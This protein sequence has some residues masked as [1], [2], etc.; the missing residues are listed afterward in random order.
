MNILHLSSEYPPQHVYGLGRYVGELAEAQAR[1]GHLVEVITNSFGGNE[2]DLV[3]NGVRVRRVHFPPP[4]KA[5]STSSMILHFNLQL[6]ER[7][8]E[9]HYG[10]RPEFDVIN[11]HDWLTFP[12]AFHLARLAKRPL[13]TTIHDVVFNKVRDRA[14]ADE[15][16]YVAG[17]ENWSCHTS[18][19]IVVLSETVRQEVLHAYSAPT[20]K[21]VIVPGGVGIEPLARHLVGELLQRRRNW[22]N[23]D[24]DLLLYVGRL[25]SEK[26]LPTLLEA[27][28]LLR[29]RRRNGW[30][31][32]LAGTGRHV[33]VLTDWIQKNEMTD[34]VRLLGYL[35]FSELRLAYAAADIAIVPSDY[36]PFG[37]VALE[38]QRMG[39]PV[40]VARTGGLAETILQTEGGLA[41]PPG[42]ADALLDSIGKLLADAFQRVKLGCNGQ[43]AVGRLFNWQSIANNRT[44]LYEKIKNSP[45]PEN[46]ELPQWK[47]PRESHCQPD[48]IRQVP[49]RARIPLS[50]FVV[51]WD[52]GRI[53][54]LQPVLDA[55]S[56]SHALSVLTGTIH[57]VRVILTPGTV[58]SMPSFPVAPCVRFI[59]LLNS[60]DLSL[61]LRQAAVAIADAASAQQLLQSGLIDRAKIPVI[62]YGS[63]NGVSLGE[64][65]V[66]HPGDL[67]TLGTK[68]LCDDGLRKR[69]APQLEYKIPQFTLKKASFTKL[70]ILHVL[71]QLVTGGAETTLL[72]LVKGTRGE[73][74][75]GVVSLG[76]LEGPLPSEF[77]N[78]GVE[79]VDLSKAD[80]LSFIQDRKPR[81]L[82][83][84]SMSYLPNW[85]PVHRQLA[86]I[87][88]V[89]TE[90]VVGI[91]SGHFGPV[92]QV[93]CVSK[94]TRAAHDPHRRNFHNACPPFSV[95]Y[96]GINIEEYRGLPSKKEAKIR[97]GLPPDRTVIGR[98]SA[99]ARNKLPRDALEVIP[100]ILKRIPNAL[101][102]IVG[103]GPQR[104]EVEIWVRERQLNQSVILLGERRDIP[105]VLRAFDVFAY[106]T[107]KDALGNVI[108]E[109][110]AAGVPVVATDIEGTREAL[111]V[112]NGTLVPLNQPELFAIAVEDAL[113]KSANGH[114]LAGLP[115]KFARKRMARRYADLYNSILT[116]KSVISAG[117]FAK[118]LEGRGPK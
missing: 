7:F 118:L 74:K 84:H 66:S 91:G 54:E 30:K 17:I 51:I 37:L 56:R 4:P 80:V 62:W 116:E 92:T 38:A 8:V 107:T 85:I 82:H 90:H 43:Q 58:L 50:D 68:L 12:A 76:P 13:V 19:R 93:V 99:L 83:L 110:I 52:A 114:R 26:G 113:A 115:R 105:Q 24:E 102:V 86:N 25:E 104:A 22:A 70:D 47:H 11:A 71:P 5:P 60:E 69:L 64:W 18:T 81:L 49:A 33:E 20:D 21:I 63:R 117:V 27:A 67:Y 34:C 103:D 36:E 2:L 3:R 10:A 78:L 72:E 53:E 23:H 95:I 42:D 100:C 46:M 94:A 75:H 88:V 89:E 109:A 40:I 29:E 44:D 112:G 39:T 16:A 65:H 73:F 96:N 35:P 41:F 15:D 97:L 6:I 106:Y 9:E 14:F 28:K 45:R 48:A 77:R 1:L 79:V 59:D 87:P 32:V 61:V 57:V 111:D 55:L 98:V 101:F 108:L 31:L